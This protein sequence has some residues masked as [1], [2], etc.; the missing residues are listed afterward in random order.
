[1]STQKKSLEQVLS[2]KCSPDCIK[3]YLN[4]FIHKNNKKNLKLVKEKDPLMFAI[5]SSLMESSYSGGFADAMRHIIITLIKEGILSFS[6][7]RN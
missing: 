4:E 6:H 1:M 5:V 3:P 7:E 2:E